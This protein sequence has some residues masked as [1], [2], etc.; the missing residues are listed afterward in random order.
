M[1]A[2]AP[3]GDPAL[4]VPTFHRYTKPAT[5]RELRNAYFRILDAVRD[6]RD[7]LVVA[8][9]SLEELFAIGNVVRW[10]EG[11]IT[12]CDAWLS[13]VARR[14]GRGFPPAV[15]GVDPVK[16][17][18]AAGLDGL[19]FKHA[20]HAGSEQPHRSEPDGDALFAAQK[21]NSCQR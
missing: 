7:A 21:G 15:V 4:Q 6:E 8:R 19:D 13:V 5:V 18:S 2:A 12:A 1:R 9:A 3:Y 16:V 17:K 14:G 11:C 20:P 10:I